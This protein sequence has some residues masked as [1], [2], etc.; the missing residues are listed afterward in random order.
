MQVRTHA[1]CFSVTK[2]VVQ[3]NEAFQRPA[4]KQSSGIELSGPTGTGFNA[5]N[6]ATKPANHTDD[7]R[8]SKTE[9]LL[10]HGVITGGGVKTG[11]SFLMPPWGGN[12]TERERWDVVAHLRT[13][14]ADMPRREGE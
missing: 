12:L 1:L 8:M 4:S 2:S 3:I 10:M 7:R 11:R 6:L 5:V 9:D 13:L 14:H